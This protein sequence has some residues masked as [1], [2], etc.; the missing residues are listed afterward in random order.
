MIDIVVDKVKIIEDLKNMLL[1]YNYALQDD[2][3]AI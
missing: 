2:D 3:K 1:G